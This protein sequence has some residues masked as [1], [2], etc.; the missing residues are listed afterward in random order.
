[1]KK[2]ILSS[3]LIFIF[4][5]ANAQENKLIMPSDVEK[6]MANNVKLGKTAEEGVVSIFVIVYQERLVK[7][8]EKENILKELQKIEG[9]KA[10]EIN[11]EKYTFQIK[12]LKERGSPQ[13]AEFKAILAGLGFRI[14]YSE[15]QL[16]LANK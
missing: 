7:E 8:Q 11:A 2:I 15:E 12:T 13:Y 3:F 10:L 16:I 5:I 4:C 14:M 1:M 6:H 9:F